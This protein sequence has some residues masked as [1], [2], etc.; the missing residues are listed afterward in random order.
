[1]A[2]PLIPF[3]I[4]LTPEALNSFHAVKASQRR[5]GDLIHYYSDSI[6]AK[7]SLK[8]DNPLVYEVW[9]ME[10]EAPGRCLSFGMTRVS[11]GKVGREYFFT[12]GHFHAG[13]DGDELYVILK[14]RGVLLLFSKDGHCETI[15]MLPD[16]IC[17]V[18]GHMAHRVVNTDSKE[19]VFFTVWPPRIVHDY[20]TITKMG[21]PKLVLAG[22]NGPEAVDNPAF[23]IV[24]D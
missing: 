6:A 10:N 1:M 19:L 3:N 5:L 8:A 15:D 16:Q 11:P 22:Q 21:F 20:A 9:E 12:R 13:E 2:L 7:E 14:G 4:P 17:Y 18:P 24:P 23:S